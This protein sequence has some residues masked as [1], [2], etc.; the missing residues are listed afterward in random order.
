M[1]GEGFEE[2]AE[3]GKQNC[4]GH[5]GP[6]QGRLASLVLYEGFLSLQRDLRVTY[7]REP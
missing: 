5:G 1:K 4:P 6:E 2:T 3:T 7:A